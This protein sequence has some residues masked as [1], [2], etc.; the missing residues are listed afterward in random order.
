MLLK[1]GLFLKLFLKLLL[2][3]KSNRLQRV[4]FY[5][6]IFGALLY[7]VIHIRVLYGSDILTRTQKSNSKLTETQLE[8]DEPILYKDNIENVHM[9]IV[10]MYIDNEKMYIDNI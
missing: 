8:S 4:V 5:I 9:Y 2:N 1:S 3:K 10:N 7:N 6:L